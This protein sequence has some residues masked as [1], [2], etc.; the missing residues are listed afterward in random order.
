[1]PATHGMSR[2]RPGKPTRL[3]RVWM[4][5]RNRCL[6]KNAISF[7]HYGGRGILICPQWDDYP[8][9]ARDVGPH[10]GTEYTLDRINTDGNYEPG[11]IRWATRQTQARNQRRV[12]LS[13]EIAAQIRSMHRPGV[14]QQTIADAVGC[15]RSMVGYIL[16]GANSKVTP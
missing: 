8:T 6:N 7:R 9:F 3:Y 11:N 1:M 2:E 14:T 10:P 15:D 13:L 4:N 16:R 5:M 12:R